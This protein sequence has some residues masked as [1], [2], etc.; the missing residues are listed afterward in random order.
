MDRTSKPA[1][2]STD[3]AYA[4]ARTP[5]VWP[6]MLPRGAR[7]SMPHKW[8][9]RSRQH[10]ASRPCVVVVVAVESRQPSVVA[11]RGVTAV[12]GVAAVTGA[13]PARRARDRQRVTVA[14]P[15]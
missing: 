6:T 11:V 5:S 13:R 9:V 1:E 10:V 2:T 14:R 7:F 12:T 3:D 4:S 8:I 15:A